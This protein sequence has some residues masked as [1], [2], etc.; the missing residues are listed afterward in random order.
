M[1]LSQLNNR[2][3]VSQE[4]LKQDETSTGGD[5]SSL[6]N[7]SAV[8]QSMDDDKHSIN[9]SLSDKLSFNI[10]MLSNIST[11]KKGLDLQ[12]NILTDIDNTV[13]KGKLSPE[14]VDSAQPA[15]AEL[16]DA[17]NRIGKHTNFNNNG[18]PESRMYFDGVYGATPISAKEISEQIQKQR[19]L[20]SSTHEYFNELSQSIRKD[21]MN[22]IKAEKDV[23]QNDSPF[24]G[25]DYSN[26]A[27]DIAKIYN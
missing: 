5:L 26:A 17:Y 10:E 21:S 6:D 12:D 15:L 8:D 2:N 11:L 4:I 25:Y 14:G 22:M 1:E 9:T 18:E 23:S 19:E 13:I 20:I 7:T 3:F 16:I 24:K 27:N